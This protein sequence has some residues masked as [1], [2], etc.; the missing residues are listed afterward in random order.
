MEGRVMERDEPVSQP[1]TSDEALMRHLAAGRQD[2][3]APLHGRYAPLI[4]SLVSQSLDR[5]AAEEIVQD[6]FVQVWRNA[7]V[8]DPTRGTFRSWVLR[9]THLRILNE[10]RRRRR[11]P[12]T[13]PDPEGRRLTVVPDPAPEPAEAV[14][15]EYRRTTIQAAVAL[16]PP[17]QRLALRLAFFEDLSHDQVA[18]FLDL[19]LGTAKT[20]IRAGLKRL[21]GHLAPLLLILVT[22]GSLLALA[23]L[24][25]RERTQTADQQRADRA[26]RL[27]TASDVV[28][29][30]L[31]A[32]PG[33]PATA[34]GSYRSRPGDGLAVLSCSNLPPL[35]TGQT[36][37]AWARVNGRWF[38]LGTLH[39][40]AQG[41]ALLIVENPLLAMPPEIVQV[42][43]EPRDGGQVP[44]G[45]PVIT[46]PAP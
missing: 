6:V 12:Q 14:W 5:T 34:H 38:A 19:P 45:P 40:D 30:H 13:M 27:L 7:A 39:P 28:S 26:L 35:P 22:I 1:D 2:A 18:A 11:R 25:A 41:G 24:I 8:F 4:F 17:P 42:T 20:R 43:R 36:Y 44:T 37:R 23:G 16:L 9:I 33:L 31:A 29:L 46:W 21:R 32:A 3:L 15:H 10:L